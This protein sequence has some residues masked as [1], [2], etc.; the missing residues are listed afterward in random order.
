[1]KATQFTRRTHRTRDI[2]T[3]VA[4]AYPSAWSAIDAFRRNRG[5]SPDFDWPDWCYMPIAAGYAIAT[6]GQNHHVP[7]SRA[8]HPAIITALATWRMT[9]GIYRYDPALYPALVD[10]PITA[11]I[12]DDALFRLPEW[13]VYIETPDMTWEGRALYGAWVH[14]EY[15][16]ARGGT[17][18]LRLVLDAATDVTD[19]LDPV[20][21]LCPVP[22]IL[23]GGDLAAALQRVIESGAAEARRQGMVVPDGA[24]T[25]ATTQVI[26]PLLSL[27]LYLCSDTPD[28]TRRGREEVPA[29]PEPVR[30]RRD[31]WRMFPADGPREWDVGVRIGA[32]LRAAYQR[33]QTGGAAAPTGRHTR[34][35]VR[36][37][38]WHTILSGPRKDLSGEP[39]PASDQRRDL[40]WM[41][42]IPINVLSP[43]ALVATIRPVKGDQSG[44]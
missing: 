18:E 22:I 34:P 11:D 23:G 36:R 40:R 42:P 3:A 6:G 14:M 43:D 32:A 15:D 30:T 17:G 27:I 13:C 4:R 20:S 5:S 16:V 9:Q 33:E 35:H 39:I 41:P 37:A 10:T 19:P 29:N 26:A 7:F 8:H 38:H 25:T 31:G 24:D 2:L 12:P 44:R 21:G 1:M 28:L